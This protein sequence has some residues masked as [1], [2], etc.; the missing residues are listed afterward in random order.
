MAIK[1][2]IKDGGHGLNTLRLVSPCGIKDLGQHWHRYW[3]G[4]ESAPA[5][6]WFW[7]AV[8]VM[9]TGSDRGPLVYFNR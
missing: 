3:P 6:H 4:T 7:S 1:Q 5:G 8:L 9:A 2:P